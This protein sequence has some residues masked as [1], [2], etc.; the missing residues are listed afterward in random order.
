[1]KTLYI[2]QI[3]DSLSESIIATFTGANHKMIK[4]QFD[5]FISDCKKKGI[6][7]D[8]FTAVVVNSCSVPETYSELVDYCNNCSSEDCFVADLFTGVENV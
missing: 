5:S 3:M 1:M 8:T 4:S 2:A 6:G 7:F